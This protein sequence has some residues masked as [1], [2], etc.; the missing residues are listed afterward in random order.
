M[1]LTIGDWVDLGRSLA[2][3][4]AHSRPQEDSLLLHLFPLPGAGPDGAS[5]KGGG[6]SWCGCGQHKG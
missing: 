2:A 3:P 1:G 4:E 5:G 6:P